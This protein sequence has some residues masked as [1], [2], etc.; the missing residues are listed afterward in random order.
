MTSFGETDFYIKWME[1]SPKA[2][3]MFFLHW[4]AF[5]SCVARFLQYLSIQAYTNQSWKQHEIERDLAT[6][7]A[8]RSSTCHTQLQ[9]GIGCLS[10]TFYAMK[11]ISRNVFVTCSEKL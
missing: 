11:L 7:L 10:L 8:R 6:Q 9:C 2:F 3:N 5:L 1:I 4:Q